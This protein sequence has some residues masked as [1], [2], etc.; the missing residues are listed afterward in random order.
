MR[1]LDY[2]DFVAANIEYLDFWVLYP[3]YKYGST[4]NAGQGG[5]LII[6]LGDISEDI[7]QD[8][9]QF[10]ENGL[11]TPSSLQANSNIGMGCSTACAAYYECI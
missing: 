11:P 8:G 5:D 2:T 10:F 3:F 6:D 9:H 4:Y 1:A 7:L